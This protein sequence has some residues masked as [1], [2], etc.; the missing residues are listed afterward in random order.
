MTLADGSFHVGTGTGDGQQPNLHQAM[1]TA[2]K[3]AYTDAM[4]R[5]CKKFGNYM[6]LSLYNGKESAKKTAY[7]TKSER[8]VAVDERAHQRTDVLVVP[9]QTMVA[10]HPTT[11]SGDIKRIRPVMNPYASSKKPKH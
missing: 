5:A 9:Q 3:G 4:K 10:S 2:K 8:D 6:G 11:S 1:D 7:S